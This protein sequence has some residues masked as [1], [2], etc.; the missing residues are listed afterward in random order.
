MRALIVQHV[1][2]EG[3]GLLHDLLAAG[4]WETEI[5]CMDQPQAALPPALKGYDCFIILG[6]PMGAYE[7]DAYPY[8]CQVQELVRQAAATRTPTLGIC[9]GGQL[10]ARALGAAVGPNRVREIGWYSL[11]LTLSGQNSPLFAGMPQQFPVFQWHGDTF[12]LPVGASRLA[13]GETCINQAFVYADCLWA[14][15]FHP[16]VTPAMVGEWTRLYRDELLEF[17]GPL[18]GET[19]M[20]E[21]ARL[22][23]EM[24]SPRERFLENLL[25]LLRRSRSRRS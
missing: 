15:Q 10:I 20:R 14:L 2:D 17:G 19:I 23:E 7:E 25:A 21:T 12:A 24:A 11:K 6:G 18:A 16:E 8:L 9:L 3:P 22:W 4:G 5:Q 1:A 13:W